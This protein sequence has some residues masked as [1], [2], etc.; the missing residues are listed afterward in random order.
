MSPYLL[1]RL[2]E[3]LQ[4]LHPQVVRL[5]VLLAVRHHNRLR[6][7]GSIPRYLRLT[8]VT[9]QV[10]VGDMLGS[11]GRVCDLVQAVDLAVHVDG[12][13]RLPGV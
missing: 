9:C 4:V 11:N 1:P 3:P 8:L 10:Q 12:G 13:V 7:S 5:L 6:V 2:L